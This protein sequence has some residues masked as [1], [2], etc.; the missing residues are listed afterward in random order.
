MKS[1]YQ[2]CAKV[3][4]A[5]HF[6]RMVEQR[7]PAQAV[8]LASVSADRAQSHALHEPPRCQCRAVD[9]GDRRADATDGSR[10]HDPF[11]EEFDAKVHLTGKVQVVWNNLHVMKRA[12]NAAADAITRNTN[13]EWCVPTGPRSQITGLFLQGETGS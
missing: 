10:L 11:A 5:S 4:A 1:W 7:A 3:V 9:R 6:C 12:F 8:S 13:C 2:L